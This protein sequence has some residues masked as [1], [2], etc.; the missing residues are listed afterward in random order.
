MLALFIFSHSVT[1]NP[2]TGFEKVGEAKLDVLFWDVYQSELYTLT[3]S[4]QKESYPQALKIHYLR[5]I[6]AEDLVER[7][8]EEWQKLGIGQGVSARWIEHIRSI[9]PN[10]KKGDELLLIV[11]QNKI[12]EFY[13]NQKSIGLIEDTEFGYNF[14]RIW[15]D[16][17]SSYPKLQKQL[18]GD[19]K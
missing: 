8:A 17:K 18:I 1:G 6:K 9:W 5:D 11:D 15:L 3:G 4:Y 13:F 16:E 2:L 14:L 12:S 19:I 7:T 10:I